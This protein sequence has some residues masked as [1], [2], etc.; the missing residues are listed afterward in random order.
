M[1][2]RGACP[3]AFTTKP[4]RAWTLAGPPDSRP[5]GIIRRTRHGE[6]GSVHDGWGQAMRP[7]L[8]CLVWE[9]DNTLWDGVVTDAT[10]GAPRPGA[11]RTLRPPAGRA[12]GHGRPGRADRP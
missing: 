9:L 12:P 8:R 4:R 6:C 5:A 1:V 3:G 7:A 11:R 10:N 2:A